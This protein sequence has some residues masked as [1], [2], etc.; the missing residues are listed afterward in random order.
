[1]TF[2]LYGN[3]NTLKAEIQC[4]ENIDFT[5]PDTIGAMLGFEPRVYEAGKMHISSRQVNIMAVNVIR[6]N[7]NLVGSSYVNG[8]P[9]SAIYEFAPVATPGYKIVEVPQ[10][11]IYVPVVAKNAREVVV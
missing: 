1:M 5:K 10:S 2:E 8:K 11:I 7:C 9:S 3:P 6:I 4:S